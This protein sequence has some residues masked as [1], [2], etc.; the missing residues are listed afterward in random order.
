MMNNSGYAS[1]PMS[2][3]KFIKTKAKIDSNLSYLSSNNNNKSFTAVN[4]KRK[5]GWDD[6]FKSQ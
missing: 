5:L 2:K 6:Y 4:T 1:R 3:S